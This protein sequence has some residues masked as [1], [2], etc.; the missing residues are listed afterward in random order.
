[1]PG[2][3]VGEC[4]DQPLETILT[5]PDSIGCAVIDVPRHRRDAGGRFRA[6]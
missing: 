6:R 4:L 1:V 5:F 3:L 2:S